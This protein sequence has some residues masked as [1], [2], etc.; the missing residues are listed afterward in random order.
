MITGTNDLASIRQAFDADATDFISPPINLILLAER[1]RYVLKSHRVLQQL[2]PL[3]APMRETAARE[4]SGS[5][6]SPFH[7]L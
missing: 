5:L 3:P 7:P 6:S 4:P 2:R 1:I